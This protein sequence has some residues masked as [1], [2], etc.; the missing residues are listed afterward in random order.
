MRWRPAT[1]L[2]GLVRGIGP[3]VATCEQRGRV[4]GIGKEWKRRKERE[5]VRRFVLSK[6]REFVYIKTWSSPYPL[7][8]IYHY[9][10][11]AS[12]FVC[13]SAHPLTGLVIG[14][15]AASVVGRST[16]LTSSPLGT[17]LVPK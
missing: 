2:L 8:P 4:D 5:V 12:P 9:R 10:G 17:L 13:A 3:V 6:E 14:V 7:S 15:A 1:A 16:V 11:S